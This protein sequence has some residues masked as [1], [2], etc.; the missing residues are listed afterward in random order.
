MSLGNV[1]DCDIVVKEFELQL[2]YLRTNTFRNG[3]NI[4]ISSSY[5][6]NSFTTILL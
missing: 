5:E 1:Q 4:L 3:M 2:R 6:L